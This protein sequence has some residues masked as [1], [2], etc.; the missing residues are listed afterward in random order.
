MRENLRYFAAVLGAPSLRRRA[1]RRGGRP[2]Q[3]RRRGHRPA[4]RRPGGARL[5]RRRAARYARG[6]RP[7][8]ADRRP[9]PRAAP[10]PVGPVP[11]PRRRRHD[12]ARQ[13]PRHGRGEPLRPAAADARAAGSSPTTPPTS[14]SSRPAPPTSRPRSSTSSTRRPRPRERGMSLD[15]HPGHRPPG[16][17]PAPPRPAHDRDAD[18]RALR[19][20][21]PARLGL[22]RH[23]RPSTSIGGPLLG[24]LPVRRHVPGHLDRHAAGAHV[25]HP[26]ATAHDADRQARPA[27]RL[28]ARVRTRRRRAGHRWPRRSSVTVFGLD[29]A[30]PFWLL[31]VSRGARRAARHGTRAVRQRVRRDRVPGRAVHAGVRAA[32]VPALRAAGAAGRDER[33]PVRGLQRPAAVLR[34]RRDARPRDATTRSAQ[35]RGATSLVVGLAIVLALG[36]GAA[37]LRRRTP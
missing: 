37:T 36:L 34:R 6:A 8:R 33:L 9:R 25:R 35:V 19:A 13:Q 5:A 28:R 15:R 16:A 1:R 4:L 17:Q 24:D 22:R 3:P 18:R 32:A 2:D 14:C 20:A 21:R 11:P 29:V 30:G 7:R 31:L 12:P 10:G 26:R 27:A 23:R